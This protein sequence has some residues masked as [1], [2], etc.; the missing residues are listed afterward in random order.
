[1]DSKK[2]PM[3]LWDNVKSDYIAGK[4]STTKEL[5]EHHHINVNTL[6]DRIYKGRWGCKP[7]RE[8]KRDLEEEIKA[9]AVEQA[10]KYLVRV[11]KVGSDI[12]LKVLEGI[13]KELLDGKYSSRELPGVLEK[14]VSAMAKANAVLRLEDGKSTQNIAVNKTQI[15]DELNDALKDLKKS[16]LIDISEGDVEVVET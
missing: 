8:E 7:W 15:S 14:T 1:M 4:F 3:E 16:G 11:Y 5:A 12:A 13:N 10:K 2:H 6:N 9:H